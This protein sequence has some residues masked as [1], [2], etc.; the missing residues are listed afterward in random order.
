M[1][2]WDPSAHLTNAQFA[3]NDDVM[4]QQEVVGGVESSFSKKSG[5]KPGML[6]PH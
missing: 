5:G 2:F 1:D 4:L 6:Y 3:R